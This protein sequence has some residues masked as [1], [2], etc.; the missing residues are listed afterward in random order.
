MQPS[1]LNSDGVVDVI[2]LSILVSRWGS[3]DVT[4][5]INSDGV[6][7][8]LD[9][10]VLVSNWGEVSSGSGT[11]LLV[12]NESV[13]SAGN[14]VLYDRLVLLGYSVITRLDSDPVDYSGIDV[15]VT[16][17]ITGSN[18]NGKYANPDVG[19]V[20]VDSWP[21]FGLG[22]QIGF[23]NSVT[24]VEVVNDSS[25]LAGGLSSGVHTVYGTAGYLV[26][27]TNYNS[28]TAAVVAVN[29]GNPTNPIVF[30]YEAGSAMQ[31]GY[32]TTRHIGLGLHRDVRANLTASGWALFDA[33]VAW[34]AASAYV[35][36]PPPSAPTNLNATAGD[37]QVSL[38]WNSVAGATSYSVKRST[39]SGGPYSIIV[40]NHTTTSYIDSSLTNGS[41]YYYV[42]SASNAEGEST[43]SSQVS[44]VPVEGGGTGG[45]DRFLYS[46]A[47]I[48][49]FQDRMLNGPYKTT[50][51]AGHGGQYSPGDGDRALSYAQTFIQDP[52]PSYWV[53]PV[54]IA[55]G[56]PWPGE[57]GGTDPHIRWMRAAWCYMTLPNHPSR[58][59]WL[60][61]VKDLLLWTSRRPEHNFENETYYP[62]E[63]YGG[64]APS[65]IFA[66]SGW[67]HRWLKARD[68]LGRSVFTNEE[69]AEL[70]RWFYGH[71]NYMLLFLHIRHGLSSAIPGRLSYDYTSTNATFSTPMSYVAYDGGPYIQG[72]GYYHTNRH[73]SM[74]AAGA[75]IANYLK[76][77]GVTP[78]PSGTAPYGYLTVDQ[79][80]I[81]AK[82]YAEEFVY[83]SLAPGGWTGDFHR[84]PDAS[85]STL[86]WRYAGQELSGPVAIAEA[87]ARRGDNSIWDYATTGGIGTM[88]GS[89]NN[90]SGVTGFPSKSLRYAAWMFSRYVND[91]WGRRLYGNP[92]VETNAYRDVLTAASLSHVY[93]SDGLLSAAWRRSGSGFPAYP[94]SPEAIGR[95][96]S[97]DGEQGKYIG[98]IEVAPT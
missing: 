76:Y 55:S 28:A 89:P 18:I 85:N 48:T 31:G 44:A 53:T 52:S 40:S 45:S 57:S 34:A 38:S 13:L 54:P 32:A 56:T 95:F 84:G 62:F 2:D 39:V 87:F 92:L 86:G 74:A 72:S 23:Q 11:A 49:V 17:S 21:H 27:S 94:S 83:H 29:P 65:P 37:M 78:T 30:G 90:T 67:M 59:Q 5:D 75:L 88:G 97:L 66:L 58:N 60:T 9:L 69:N 26:W 42:V 73:A 35:A 47:D 68:M 98:L 46:A 8:A 14:Q 3:S 64:F 50:G 12:T 25:P 20:C 41:T 1:D 7:D 15:M 93:P 70:D 33:A 81:H 80:L 63:G 19:L 91:G 10:S 16:G 51:D 24:D 77:Y 71:A 43:N 82:A 4:A 61:E 22:D 96:T 36:P 79:M 6:V